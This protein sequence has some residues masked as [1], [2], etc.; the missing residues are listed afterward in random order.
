MSNPF[1]G[2]AG[3]LS[4]VTFFPIANGAQGLTGTQS[5]D[6]RSSYPDT[7]IRTIEIPLGVPGGPA[8]VGCVFA[9][10][11]LDIDSLS[12]T[13]GGQHLNLY[14]TVNGSIVATTTINDGSSGRFY[15]QWA[16]PASFNRVGI[17]IAGANSGGGIITAT[18]SL[19]PRR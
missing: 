3:F 10:A 4:K 17:A 13:I 18:W 7:T 1:T 14:I 11:I 15:A 5:G 9:E 2:V 16:D 19:Q 8:G 12:M 6:I